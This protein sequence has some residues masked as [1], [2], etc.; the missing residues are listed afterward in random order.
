MYLTFRT[1]LLFII[2]SPIITAAA[3]T[4]G[5]R[6]FDNKNN[7][8]TSTDCFFYELKAEDSLKTFFCSYN[9]LR[10]VVAYKVGM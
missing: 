1:L 8:A 10:S 4:P 3:Q 2:L 6:Y 5:Y 9:V 7:L